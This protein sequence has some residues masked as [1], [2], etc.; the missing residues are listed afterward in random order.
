MNE[1]V[2][3][4]YDWVPPQPRGLVRD[5]RV[6]WAL[7]EAGLP[8]RVASVPFGDRK[9]EHFAH[10]PFGQVPWLTDG[11]LS[12]FESGAILLHLGQLSAALM[13]TDPR[14]RSKA[15]EWVFAAL[16][17]VEMASLPWSMFKFTGEPASKFLDEF[18]KIRLKHLEAVLAEREWLAGSFSVADILMADVLRP[19][20]RFDGL[21][22]HPACC[23]YV[24]RATARPAFVKAHADQMAHFAAAD[25][26][27][28]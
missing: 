10:Q 11:D 13:P 19:V 15:M 14:G 20:D 5:L 25:S 16:N 22:D 28:G 1:L 2:L 9:P 4:T 6:R 24:A 8:Y 7:E 23:D 26:R 18:L 3:T 17:S 21:A 27:A 12:I